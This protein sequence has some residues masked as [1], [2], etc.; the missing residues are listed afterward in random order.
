MPKTVIVKLEVPSRSRPDAL[1]PWLN[2]ILDSHR[3]IVLEV[4]EAPEDGDAIPR[5]FSGRRD[6]HT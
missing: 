5:D 4:V 6:S 2:R 3:M 1:K